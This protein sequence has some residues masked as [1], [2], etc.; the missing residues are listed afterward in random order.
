MYP[1]IFN[2]INTYPVCIII[3]IFISYYILNK[4]A[5]KNNIDKTFH[6]YFLNTAITAVVVGFISAMLFQSFYD[7][8]EEPCEGFK[9]KT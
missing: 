1:K 8:L 7:Y 2:L 3:G 5:N 9:F 6:N 4:F